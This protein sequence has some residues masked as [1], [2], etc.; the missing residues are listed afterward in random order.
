MPRFLI[1]MPPMPEAEVKRT[2]AAVFEARRTA[3]DDS[4]KM[5]RAYVD[6]EGGKTICCWEGRDKESIV[7]LFK[8]ADVVFESVSQVEEM[9][10]ADFV[11]V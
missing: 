7:K 8:Q 10:E 11:W 3:G 2:W 1:T 9:L 5:D 4:L 6:N